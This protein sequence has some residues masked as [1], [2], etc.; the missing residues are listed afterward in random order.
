[1]NKRKIL[2]LVRIGSKKRI[3]NEGELKN[4]LKTC[5]CV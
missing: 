4:M 3:I 5:G 2:G 1:M